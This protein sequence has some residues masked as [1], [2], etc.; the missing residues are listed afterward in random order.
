M[1]SPELKKI[2]EDHSHW[3]RTGGAEGTRLDLT[4][5]N[6]SGAYLCMTDLSGAI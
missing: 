1:R 2:L 4:G 3:L 6:L 5:A